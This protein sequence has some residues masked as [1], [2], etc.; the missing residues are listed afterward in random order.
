MIVCV[1][2]GFVHSP[3][4][5]LQ[6]NRPL[7]TCHLHYYLDGNLG[8]MSPLLYSIL[9]EIAPTQCLQQENPE[10]VYYNIGSFT[11]RSVSYCWSLDSTNLNAH[12]HYELGDDS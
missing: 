10:M 4:I 7:G 8:F 3:F 5:S 2:L 1:S 9:V 12:L 11:R 6:R